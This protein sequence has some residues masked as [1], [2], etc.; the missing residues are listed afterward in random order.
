MLVPGSNCCSNSYQL[1]FLFMWSGHME[2]S[3][4]WGVFVWFALGVA[5]RMLIG[6]HICRLTGIESAS[7]D[8]RCTRAGVCS[9]AVGGWAHGSVTVVAAIPC[10]QNDI[11]SNVSPA[12]AS[13]R[14][15]AGHPGSLRGPVAGRRGAPSLSGH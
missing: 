8:A 10:A 13:W 14:C 9:A 3:D 15:V 5:Y 2:P 6:T 12:L 1:I 7:I 4:I 11:L